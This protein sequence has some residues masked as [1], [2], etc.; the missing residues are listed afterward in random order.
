L[1]DLAEVT[2]K[3]HCNYVLAKLHVSNRTR[4]ALLAKEKGVF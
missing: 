2:V 4:A 1:L 3:L